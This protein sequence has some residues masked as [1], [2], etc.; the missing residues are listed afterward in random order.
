MRLRRHFG[1]VQNSFSSPLVSKNVNSEIY[2]TAIFPDVLHARDAT[3]R[4]LKEGHSLGVFVNRVNEG[5][6]R[7]PNE[8]AD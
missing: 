5:S 8:T 3:S 1:P 2:K 6:K 7:R 4:T